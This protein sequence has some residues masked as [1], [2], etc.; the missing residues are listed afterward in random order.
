MNNLP[1]LF[2]FH[3]LNNFWWDLMLEGW[4]LLSLAIIT[5]CGKQSN[6]F[7]KSVRRAPK[8]FLVSTTLL[9][10]SKMVKSNA[11]H[12]I[13]YENHA[14]TSTKIDKRKMSFGQ[15][16]AVRKFWKWQEQYSQGSSFLQNLLCYFWITNVILAFFYHRWKCS[17]INAYVEK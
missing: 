9:H 4:T 7:N 17:F 5:L 2:V 11:E 15:I 8:T 6:A 16:T 1:C 14:I 10:F 13:L 12:C 3:W